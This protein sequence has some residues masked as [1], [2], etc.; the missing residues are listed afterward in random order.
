MRKALPLFLVLLLSVS[1]CCPAQAATRA[2]VDPAT[3]VTTTFAAQLQLQDASRAVEEG[4]VRNFGSMQNEAVEHAKAAHCMRPLAV[5]DLPTP[6]NDASGPVVRL[7]MFDYLLEKDCTQGF[8]YQE[9]DAVAGGVAQAVAQVPGCL[10]H[11]SSPM[12]GLGPGQASRVRRQSAS[13]GSWS[14]FDRNGDAALQGAHPRMDA[15]DRF[16][17]D[18]QRV[19]RYRGGA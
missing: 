10:T 13:R 5:A 16:A 12:V 18:L 14:C 19:W 3:G 6:V 15:D 9:S 11:R 17:E 7:M 2:F 1:K 4:H 8:K